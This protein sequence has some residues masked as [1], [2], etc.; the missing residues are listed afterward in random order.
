LSKAGSGIGIAEDKLAKVF[1]ALVQ[2]D[3]SITRRFG[4]NGLELTIS[5]RLVQLMGGRIWVESE[6]GRGSTFCFTVRTTCAE[7]DA[8]SRV[9]P[10]AVEGV[11]V[12]VVDDNATNRLILHE[13]LSGWGMLAT[14]T[15]GAHEALDALRQAAQAG[16]PYRLVLS[17]L[18]MPEVDGVQLVQS[19]RGD[20]GSHHL[21]VIVLTSGLGSEDRRRLEA[22]G[23]VASLMKPVK[24]SELLDAVSV[25]LGMAEAREGPVRPGVDA[26]PLP[27]LRILLAEDSVVNQKLAIG[28]LHKF[29]HKV[30]VANNGIEAV[31]QWSSGAYD[32]VLMDIEMPQMNGIQATAAIR[33]R[34]RTSGRHVPDA[35]RTPGMWHLARRLQKDA[36][37]DD[38]LQTGAAR[39]FRS[40]FR[41]LGRAGRIL[42][43][44]I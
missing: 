11:R 13:I 12:L 27:P 8:A 15:A 6:A 25:A 39:S 28:L 35:Q 38:K 22:L 20:A 34:E 23:V 16:N 36:S 19:I 3:A 17:D 32:V 41:E 4:G 42:N 2:A 5:H 30:T 10:A 33:A 44:Y 37:S 14:V 1:E 26:A 9:R 21:Q 40:V 29:G 24:Q 31:E 18:N 7:D 43:T